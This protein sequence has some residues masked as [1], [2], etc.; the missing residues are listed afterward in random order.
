M[1][2]SL[3]TAVGALA[4]TTLFAG[5]ADARITRIQIAKT[6]PAF[7][8]M[9]F[10]TVGPYER[11]TG[12]AYGEVDPK[13]Q[14]NAL[15]QDI[16]L[17]PKNSRGMV[18]Y[19]TDID[20]LRPVNRSKSNG[21]LFFNIVNRGNKGGLQLFDAGV[22]GGA[23]DTNNLANPG[24][25]FLMRSGYTMVWFGWQ[26]DVVPGGGRM[27]MTVPV[28]H[29]ADGSAITG[30]VR[31]ELTSQTPTNTL[32]LASGWFTANSAPYPTVSTDNRAPLA[33][34]FL[35]TLTI[36]NHQQDPRIPIP[37][38]EWSFG[39]CGPNNEPIPSATQ[40]CYPAG[41]KPGRLYEI[42]YRAKDPLILGLGFAV[43]RDLGSFLRSAEKDDNGTPNPVLT[44]NVRT[45]LMGQSQSGRYV[46][47][48]IRLGFNQGEDGKIVFDGAFPEI[49]G[50]LA[51][52][53]RAL[54]PA[55]PRRRK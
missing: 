49:G 4:I 14:G 43:T 38:T 33:D 48:F 6:E 21:I 55:R 24:D 28:A 10:G 46:R 23:S 42:T 36:R 51:A 16:K 20:I 27:N 35:P 3:R 8:G 18:E 12:K 15:I 53:Q 7:G 41:F 50:G 47:T 5:L 13:A 2:L 44:P 22:P 37:N 34:G 29:N 25:G 30:V 26:A 54:G 19:V 31:S 17:A 11:L 1:H 39:A 40:I 9:S 52:A 45:I 32:S